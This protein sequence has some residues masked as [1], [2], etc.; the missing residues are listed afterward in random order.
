MDELAVM[1]PKKSLKFALDFDETYTEDPELWNHFIC[2]CYKRGHTVTFVTY[3]F[4]SWENTDIKT[5]AHAHG[6]DIVFTAGK[7]KMHCFAADIW[8]D[9]SPQTIVSYVDLSEMIIGCEVNK[10]TE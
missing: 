6:M 8:I 9:D 10:D 7:Q 5:V 4:D 3:R 2:N 1:T